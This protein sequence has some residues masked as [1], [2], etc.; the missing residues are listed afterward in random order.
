MI[1]LAE[2]DDDKVVVEKVWA[3]EKLLRGVPTAVDLR[4]VALGDAE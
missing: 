2:E 4:L 1:V 3:L